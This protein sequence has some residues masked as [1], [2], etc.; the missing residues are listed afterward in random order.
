MIVARPGPSCAAGF[1]VQIR[2]DG[3]SL[4]YEARP[5]GQPA[6]R[7]PLKSLDDGVAVFEN[8][9]HD[10]PQ[11]IIYRR[12]P[13]GIAARIEGTMNGAPRAVDPVVTLRA[14]TRRVRPATTFWRRPTRRRY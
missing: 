4:V 1:R 11:R 12:T 5:S 13:D 10:F 7:F 6:A 3:G 8:P 9:A 2:E 14:M